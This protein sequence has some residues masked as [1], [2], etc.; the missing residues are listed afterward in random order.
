M[1]SKI[2]FS[3]GCCES[4]RPKYCFF[5]CQKHAQKPHCEHKN[6]NK[7]LTKIKNYNT[8]TVHL[9]PRF[10]ISI[11]LIHLNKYIYLLLDIFT[12]YHVRFHRAQLHGGLMDNTHFSIFILQH[13]R[14]FLL[15]SAVPHNAEAQTALELL[16][17]SE[18]IH[19]TE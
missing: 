13:L 19:G 3:M 2:I 4:G 18:S 14:K 17:D 12:S 11:I 8:T 1:E 10:H 7:T 9:C 5:R 6:T 16:I 15:L